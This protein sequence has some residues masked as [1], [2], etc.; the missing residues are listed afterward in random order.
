MGGYAEASPRNFMDCG[1]KGEAFYRRFFRSFNIGLALIDK[2]VRGMP[3]PY[4]VLRI[5]L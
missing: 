5:F 2:V 1:C 3:R 4:P